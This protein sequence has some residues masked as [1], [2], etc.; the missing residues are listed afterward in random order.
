MPL[1]IL[2]GYN[3]IADAEA[4][5]L[6]ILIYALWII[7]GLGLAITAFCVTW[8]LGAETIATH[9]KCRDE[10]R[11]VSQVYLQATHT[12]VFFPLYIC[13][14]AY[15]CI[16]IPAIS[17]I[18]E[19][20]IAIGSGVVIGSLTQY[21]LSA[22]GEPPMPHRLLRSIPPKK[23]WWG[24]LCGGVNDMLPLMGFFFSPQ[25]HKL[26]VWHLRMA[27]HM[28][29]FFI[30]TF[31]MFN[32]W[33]LAMMAVPT[34]AKQL[35]DGF[36][37]SENVLESWSITVFIVGSVCST[38]VGMAGFSVIASAVSEA[39]QSRQRP[40]P[41][42]EQIESMSSEPV[43]QASFRVSQ[44]GASASCYL[45]L[46][47]SKLV[48][49]AIP[50]QFATPTIQLAVTE[51][52]HHRTLTNGTIR[53]T[54]EGTV[55][56]CPVFDKQVMGSMLYCTL[57]TVTMAW[58]AISNFRNYPPADSTADQLRKHL[59]EALSSEGSASINSAALREDIQE[60]GEDEQSEA[61]SDSD[62]EDQRVQRGKHQTH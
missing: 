17:H 25:P 49:S 6:P 61:D 59:E 36:C 9:R 34:P 27:F 29:A 37:I 55:L 24:S 18:M 30:W 33:Q 16:F 31:I 28:V 44:K 35:P 48:L 39:L 10:G 56:N 46:P 47:L 53:W 45:L 38:F 3:A 43:L 42:L 26:E 40:S 15:T 62:E 22:L 11:V 58:L 1:A 2:W 60:Q 52:S 32:C 4:E 23:W 51:S 20:A 8:Q 19:L 54:T 41:S 13:V 12:V 50:V 7:G 57:V 5:G 21:L 14:L